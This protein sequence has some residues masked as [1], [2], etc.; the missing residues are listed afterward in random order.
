MFWSALAALY[1][2][3]FA[4]DLDSTAVSGAVDPQATYT[5]VQSLVVGD[6]VCPRFGSDCRNSRF[7][8]IF[9]VFSGL[10]RLLRS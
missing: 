10:K 9:G 4:S 7:G 8:S 3:A 6:M 5:A 2:V 1:L